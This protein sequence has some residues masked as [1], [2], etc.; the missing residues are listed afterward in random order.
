MKPSKMRILSNH[1]LSLSNFNCFPVYLSMEFNAEALLKFK[2]QNGFS[3]TA[4]LTK[5]IADIFLENKKFK[6]L[7]SYLL[8]SPLIK[9]KLL[10]FDEVSFS[11]ALPK[12]YQGE[13]VASLHILKNL[14]EKSMEQIDIELKNANKMKIEDMP[15]FKSMNTLLKIPQFLYSPLFTLLKLFPSKKLVAGSSI[16]FSNLGKSPVQIF[17]PQSPKTLMLG[18]GGIYNKVIREN[19]NFIE[20][21]HMSF[22]LTFNHYVVDGLI[23]S[24]FLNA[25]KIKL[26]RL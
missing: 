24:D 10:I 7:N 14:N 3:M 13:E 15:F 23:C 1:L 26:E 5:T 9:T 11:I 21:K 25:L 19:E 12:L 6:I 20:A 18:L 17:L 16:G 4:I 22:G 2:K 8:K